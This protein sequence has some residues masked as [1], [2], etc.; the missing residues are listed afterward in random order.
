MKQKKIEIR[1]KPEKNLVKLWNKYKTEQSIL[2]KKVQRK[3]K[4]SG[5]Q[6]HQELLLNQSK[7][8]ELSHYLKRLAILRHNL[9]WLASSIEK[10]KGNPLDLEQAEWKLEHF[11]EMSEVASSNEMG[12][13]TKVILTAN[14][15]LDNEIPTPQQQDLA[16]LQQQLFTELK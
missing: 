1:Q 11:L 12:N 8:K 2:Q 14:A 3:I 9:K 13:I 15:T 16:G 5:V 7:H 6:S 4:Q 10:A